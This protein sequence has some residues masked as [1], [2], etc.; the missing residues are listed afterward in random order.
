VAALDEDPTPGG[1]RD[2]RYLISW[3]DP[4][5]LGTQ[6]WGLL[7]ELERRGFHV[8][9]L[10]V[11]RSVATPHRVMDPAQATRLLHLAIGLDVDTW[12]DRPDARR[13]AY[14]D[15]RTPSERVEYRRL[16]LQVINDL[17]AAGLADL[18]PQV[19]RSLTHLA[20]DP[21]LP[22]STYAKTVRMGRLGLPM[23]VFVARA[24]GIAV[25]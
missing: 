12:S 16:R 17:R 15:P 19:D 11:Y 4:I 5:N 20:T 9:T 21:R 18:V 24:D 23:A 7:N 22:E 25:R 8:G 13:V 3:S 1:G 10:A 6:G 2:G 14:L